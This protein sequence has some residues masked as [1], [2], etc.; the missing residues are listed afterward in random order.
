MPV[1]RTGGKV[2]KTFTLKAQGFMDVVC[3]ENHPFYARKKL[4][5]YYTQNNG[6]K[7]KRMILSDPEWINAGNLKGNYYVCS[8]MQ[9]LS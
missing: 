4:F 1:L 9:N 6:R 3:T 7:S 2:S 5:E 8:N